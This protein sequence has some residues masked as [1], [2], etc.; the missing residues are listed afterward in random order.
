MKKPKKVLMNFKITEN[1][2]KELELASQ[3]SG[4]S[5]TNIILQGALKEAKKI[6]SDIEK[7]KR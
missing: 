7:G 5:M 1:N 3:M 4:L 2:K 6:L